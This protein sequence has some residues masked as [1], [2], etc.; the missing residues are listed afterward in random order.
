MNILLIN[1]YAG[2]TRHGMEFRPFYLAREWVRAGHR[3]QI[4]AA[5]FSHIRARQPE[6]DGAVLEEQIEGID[7]R[8]LVTPGYKGNGAGRVKNMLAF[9][10]ALWRDSPRL[11]R[12]FKPDVVIASSTYPMD[13]WPARRIAR[14]SKARLVYEVHDLWPLS[15][16]ELGGLSRWHPFIIWVQMAEDYAYRHADKVVSMLPK[17]GQYMCSRGMA[18]QK[19]TYVPNGVD[20]QEWAQPADLPQPVKAA[21]DTLRAKGLP[22]VG[23]AGTHGL[24]NALD[25]LLDAASQLKGKAEVVIVGTGPDRDALLARVANEDLSN[26]TMLPAIP[27]QSVPRFL[28][29]VDIAYIGW[30]PNPLYRFG[31]SPNKLMDY[32]MAGKP[33]V[34]SV[35]AGNDPVAEAGCGFTVPPGDAAAVAQAILKLA[36]MSDAQRKLLGAAGKRFILKNQTYPRLA[37]NFLAATARS[38]S[39]S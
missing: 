7:Y 2:S 30:H 25:V 14:L 13:I 6:L 24:S 37:A 34:H 20:E 9:M 18:P 3:V 28:D 1:H 4:V 39:V 31:I 38:A 16:M 32:M 11:A 22:L 23:Y 12:E 27:K 36:A 35:S 15:P 8:W 17:A 19:F 33:V 26:V 10:W 5:S 21:L 29:G